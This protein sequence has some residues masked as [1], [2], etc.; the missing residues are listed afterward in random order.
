MVSTILSALVVIAHSYVG[1]R[2]VFVRWDTCVTCIS[3]LIQ[4]RA[5][6]P[7]PTRAHRHPPLQ[8]HTRG[9][10]GLFLTRPH[11]HDKNTHVRARIQRSTRAQFKHAQPATAWGGNT[12]RHQQ[13]H[14]GEVWGGGRARF[15]PG[16]MQPQHRKIQRQ[17]PR[18]AAM[19]RAVM[20]RGD[21][22]GDGGGDDG[23]GCGIRRRRT[24]R[25][26]RRRRQRQRRR[27]RSRLRRRKR[28]WRRR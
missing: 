28:W 3:S 18:R 24:R 21:G 9:G 7:P 22:G 27:R 26:R 4:N 6:L 10:H 5:T 13:A 14:C 19:A 8:R 15:E 16:H 25:P 2:V 20:A 17:A 12:N 11:T 23:E 1:G